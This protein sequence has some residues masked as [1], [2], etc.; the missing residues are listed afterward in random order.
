MIHNL[1]ILFAAAAISAP[2]YAA[3]TTGG[4]DLAQIDSQVAAFTG[5]PQGAVGG[6]VLPVDRRLRL[7]ACHSPL[8]LGWHTARK[9]SVVVQC[10]DAG[11]WRLFVPVT[12]VQ[13]TAA[14]APEAPAVAR[15]EAVTVSVTGDGFAVSQ[16]G[17]TLD[18]GAVGAWVRVRM[19][20]GGAPKGDAMRAQVIRPGLLA[21]PMD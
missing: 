11:S 19:V 13:Q 7:A 10:T 14:A 2:A 4:T 8:S 12:P 5:A 6:A 16:P 21:I 3:P 18:A 9:E 1:T 15:G 17:I 20:Q